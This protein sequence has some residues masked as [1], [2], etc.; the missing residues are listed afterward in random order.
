MLIYEWIGTG[1]MIFY[2][3]RKLLHFILF[4]WAIFGFMD[5]S[6]RMRFFYDYFSWFR[7]LSCFLSINFF[8]WFFIV[9]I[10]FEY[11]YDIFYFFFWL[12]IIFGLVF[13][14]INFFLSLLLAYGFPDLQKKTESAFT[15][16]CRI[17]Y[18]LMGTIFII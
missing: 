1:F 18:I 5:R 7:F 9:D 13:L 3:N 4:F 15:W 6:S 16:F 8:G 17:F 14:S 10:I 11:F 12:L 2:S